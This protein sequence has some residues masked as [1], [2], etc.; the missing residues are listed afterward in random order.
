MR[1]QRSGRVAVLFLT[2]EGLPGVGSA[3]EQRSHLRLGFKVG[4]EGAV[5]QIWCCGG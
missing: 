4:D 5:S 3:G 2:P 1:S